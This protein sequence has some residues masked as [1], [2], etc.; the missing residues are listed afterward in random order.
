MLTL[1]NVTIVVDGEDITDAVIYVVPCDYNGDGMVSV[2]DAKF[3]YAAAGTGANAEYC[4]LNGDTM[5]S[6]PDTK[7]VYKFAAG[8]V[9]AP[10]TIA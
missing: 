9:L 2:P 8:A 4:D 10:Q 3:V 1:E 6:V 5:V 7:I